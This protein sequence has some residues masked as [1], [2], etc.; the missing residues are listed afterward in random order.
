MRH[1]LFEGKVTEL[2]AASLVTIQML[3]ALDL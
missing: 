2:G 3:A 1:A